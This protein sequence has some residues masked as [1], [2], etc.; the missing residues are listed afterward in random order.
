M[1][2]IITLTKIKDRELYRHCN[3]IEEMLATLGEEIIELEDLEEKGVEVKPVD[4]G[5]L[6][7]TVDVE[8]NTP[9]Y[10]DFRSQDFHKKEVA[11]EAF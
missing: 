9:E 7:L 1:S 10:I 5:L 11:K 2:K 8:E 4:T 3:S 6:L